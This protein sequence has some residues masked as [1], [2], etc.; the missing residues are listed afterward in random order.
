MGRRPGFDQRKIGAIVAA[1][2]KNPD[3]LWLR[4]I[5]KETEMTHAT[6]AK[7]VEGILRPLVE[8]VSLGKEGKPLLRVIRL[9]PFV[10]ERLQEGKS[11]AD[12]LKVLRLMSKVEE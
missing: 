8:E 9:K 3:G 11:I 5:A 1:L 4:Q 7:Y 2:Y 12:I 6:V 10:I